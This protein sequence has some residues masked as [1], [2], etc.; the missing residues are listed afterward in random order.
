M[1]LVYQIYF[2]KS[3]QISTAFALE[4]CY[5]NCRGGMYERIIREISTN[6]KDIKYKERE[7]V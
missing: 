2:A 7:R 3:I 5:N 6:D 1:R 4:K